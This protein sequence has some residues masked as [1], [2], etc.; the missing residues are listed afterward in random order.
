MSHR[1]I[2]Q[3]FS[4]CQ[5][6]GVIAKH[7]KV[8]ALRDTYRGVVLVHA[9]DRISRP[10]F[11]QLNEG[12]PCHIEVLWICRRRKPINTIRIRRKLS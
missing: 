7:D 11:S 1:S 12:S 5:Y 3:H 9:S 6:R 8:R 10:D 2:S 4:H